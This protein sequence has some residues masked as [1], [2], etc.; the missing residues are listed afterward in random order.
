MRIEHIMEFINQWDPINLFPGAPSDEYSK[1]I[2]QIFVVVNS[3][4]NLSKCELAKQIEKIF[5][6]TFGDE[7]FKNKKQDCLRIASKIK[8][9]KSL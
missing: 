1:E 3:N 9:D 7:A 2:E 4:Q 6:N 5:I 8:D